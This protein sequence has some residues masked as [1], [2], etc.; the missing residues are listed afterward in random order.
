MVTPRTDNR[1]EY[2]RAVSA[3]TRLEVAL[4]LMRSARGEIAVTL[5]SGHPAVETV[6]QLEVILGRAL[7][8]LQIAIKRIP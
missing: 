6:R 4:E 7:A 1:I 8:K 2:A 5:Q 3:R